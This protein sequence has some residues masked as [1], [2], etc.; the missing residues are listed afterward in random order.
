MAITKTLR[1]TLSLECGHPL[2]AT[3]IALA[4]FRFSPG[5]REAENRNPIPCSNVK[6]AKVPIGDGWIRFSV[7]LGGGFQRG[8]VH[9]DHP[10]HGFHGFRMTD[11]LADTARHNLPA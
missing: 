4:E 7:L 2:R 8:Q 11:Q 10:H 6:P 9:L 1:D 3:S 5:Y